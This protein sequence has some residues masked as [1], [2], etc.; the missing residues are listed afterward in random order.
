[1]VSQQ[2]NKTYL[3]ILYESNKDIMNGLQL[4]SPSDDPIHLNIHIQPV[5]LL[6]FIP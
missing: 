4:I 3:S 5:E 6:F 2:A 1:M